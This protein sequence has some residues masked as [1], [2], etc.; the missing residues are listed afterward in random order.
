MLDAI[1]RGMHDVNAVENITK[2]Q[3]IY[4]MLLLALNYG[5]NPYIAEAKFLRF[6]LDNEGFGL[7]GV[8]KVAT[9]QAL[10]KEMNYRN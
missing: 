9:R 1:H 8:E 3:F 7:S 6:W 2:R 5:A 10:N 4:Q